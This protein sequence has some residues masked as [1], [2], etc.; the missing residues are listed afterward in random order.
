MGVAGSVASGT[1][2]TVSDAV[3]KGGLTLFMVIALSIHLLDTFAGRGVGG[4]VSL[5][6]SRFI[7]LQLFLVP[8]LGAFLI[9]GIRTKKGLAT[10]WAY[11]LAAYLLPIALQIPFLKDA[12]T[13]GLGIFVYTA[14][15][16]FMPVWIIFFMGRGDDEKNKW[17]G[18]IV[19]VYSFLW[20]LSILVVF[21]V[22]AFASLDF[23]PTFYSEGLGGAL[24]TSME[25]L[26]TGVAQI[27]K[28]TTQSAD[29]VKQGISGN[30]SRPNVARVLT[31]S[32]FK[33]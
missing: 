15:M 14:I 17:L 25:E 29:A 4:N 27:W 30:A 31:P 28:T 1:K 2:K 12:I 6:D 23:G 3:S 11:A 19:G 20:I 5:F 18:R 10:V 8:I 7:F 9:P 26:G 16:V 24:T 21:S 33:A 13:N 22:P 32:D